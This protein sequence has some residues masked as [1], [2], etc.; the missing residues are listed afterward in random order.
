MAAIDDLPLM[1][2]QFSFVTNDM[3]RYNRSADVLE[4]ILG[5]IREAMDDNRDLYLYVE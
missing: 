2:E 5:L 1:Y 4:L 3:L